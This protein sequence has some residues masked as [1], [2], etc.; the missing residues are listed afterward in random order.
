MTRSLSAKGKF[1]KS[2]LKVWSKSSVQK[3]MALYPPFFEIILFQG[4]N[5]Q[6]MGRLIE[7]WK[8]KQ[9]SGLWLVW[10]LKVFNFLF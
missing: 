3:G 4:E 2:F 10:Y 8:V 7:L 6:L 9:S 5:I 1:L